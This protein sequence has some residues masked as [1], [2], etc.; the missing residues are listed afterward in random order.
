MANDV[1]LEVQIS[2]NMIE[3]KIGKSIESFSHPFAF[4]AYKKNF[5]NFLFHT[6]K[7]CGYQNGVTTN[8]GTISAENNPFFL[9]RIP[10]NSNDDLL[11]FQAKLEGGYDWLYPLQVVK[12]ALRMP[13]GFFNFKTAYKSSKPDA[14]AVRHQ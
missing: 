9:K 2:K 8:I 6:L 11:F 14:S 10:V 7:I 1:R 13:G 12:K 5:I 3:D 4:P